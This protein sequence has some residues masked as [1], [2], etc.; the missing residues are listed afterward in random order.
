MVVVGMLTCRMVLVVVAAREKTVFLCCGVGCW[1][2][3]I[4]GSDSDCGGNGGGG[5]YAIGLG[6]S[7]G[8]VGGTGVVAVLVV[9]M[10]GVVIAGI[11]GVVG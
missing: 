6:D 3:G 7:F 1:Q 2:L 11:L 9:E 4:G 10:A 5:C 8:G